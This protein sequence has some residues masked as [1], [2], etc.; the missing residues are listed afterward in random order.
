MLIELWWIAALLFTAAVVSDVYDG[1][2]ARK[3]NQV[4]PLGGLLDHGTDALF[5][6]GGC[7]AL[8]WLGLVPLLLALLIPSAFIQYMLDSKALAGKSLRT[9]RLGKSNGVAYFALVGTAIGAHTLMQINLL[10]GLPLLPLWEYIIEPGLQIA[11][12]ILIVSTIISMLDR[13]TTLV[14]EGGT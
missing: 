4:S 14:R 6:T 9:S 10:L 13:L 5:V 12:W 2:L 3:Y 8:A 11:A 1:K 7:L